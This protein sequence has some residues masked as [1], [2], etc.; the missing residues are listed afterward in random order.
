[1][2]SREL[3]RD[4]SLLRI[5][6]DRRVP[7]LEL[8]GVEEERPVDVL[9]ER[10]DVLLDHARAGERRRREVVLVPVDRR[11]ARPRLAQREQRLAALLGMQRAEAVLIGAVLRVEPGAPV[12]VE[13]VADDAD[14]A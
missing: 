5:V 3:A 12:A 2:A 8:P 9:A 14:H 10:R 6:E 13:Q 4:L 7:A 1:M 11:P